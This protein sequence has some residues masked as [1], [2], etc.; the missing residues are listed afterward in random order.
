[1]EL[2]DISEAIKILKCNSQTF[3]TWVRRGLVPDNLIFAI[4]KTKRI[5]KSVLEKWING[6]L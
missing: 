6:D 3:R 5:R 1:M 4:G 2:L